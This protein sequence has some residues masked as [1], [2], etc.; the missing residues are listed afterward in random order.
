MATQ[1]DLVGT[2]SRRLLSQKQ[3]GDLNFLLVYK[4]GFICFNDMI[5][6][7]QDHD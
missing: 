6:E 5:L 2:P 3:E 4:Y 1:A 7:K